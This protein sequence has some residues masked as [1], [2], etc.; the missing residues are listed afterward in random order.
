[1]LL[2]A[3]T[4]GTMMQWTDRATGMGLR[5]LIR[6][7]NPPIKDLNM[8]Y[9]DMRTKDFE[10]CFDRLGSLRVFGIVG[11]DLSDTVV[12]LLRPYRR[13]M[14]DGLSIALDDHQ[15][16][17]SLV[18]V[19]IADLRSLHLTKCPGFTGDALVDA[20]SARNSFARDNPDSAYA[21]KHVRV[22]NCRGFGA[23]HAAAL[24]DVFRVRLNGTSD[25]I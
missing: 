7:C 17:E 16:G 2:R 13:A 22:S 4:F 3:L 12:N 9:A 18:R 10:W 20:L 19:R 11:S 5:N 21:I 6:R 1:M 24:S 14:Q 23:E 25:Q 8:D 15:A